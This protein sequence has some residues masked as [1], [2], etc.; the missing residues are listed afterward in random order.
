MG[1]TSTGARTGCFH[2]CPFQLS[3]SWGSNPA[4]VKASKEVQNVTRAENI[5]VY[6]LKVLSVSI[7]TTDTPS[8]GAVVTPDRFGETADG[9]SL[10]PTEGYSFR[11]HSSSSFSM[12]KFDMLFFL[13]IFFYRVF[14]TS[15]FTSKNN[16]VSRKI[17][18]NR[19]PV[20]GN[21]E[22]SRCEHQWRCVRYKATF[23]SFVK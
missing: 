3:F 14:F 11:L 4:R 6:I 19:N 22:N 13:K 16:R 1:R 9:S 17:S 8:I 20:K 7:R 18:Y 2:Y 15:K 12:L 5:L 21:Y 10:Y 23:A